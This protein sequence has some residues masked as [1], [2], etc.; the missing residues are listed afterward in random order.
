MSQPAAFR[1]LFS[2]V[3]CFTSCFA[4]L[5]LVMIGH[6]YAQQSLTSVPSGSTI[7]VTVSAQSPSG[8]P[9]SYRWLATDGVVANANTP[10]TSPN[11]TWTLPK[12]QG[13]HFL[14]VLVSDSQGGYTEKRI[15]IF[16]TDPNATS[17]AVVNGDP[18]PSIP[19][20][21]PSPVPLAT[22]R[23]WLQDQ[24]PGISMQL[25]DEFT[26]KQFGPVITDNEGQFA[27]HNLPQSTYE[28]YIADAPGQPF[29]VASELNGPFSV[30][31]NLGTSNYSDLGSTYTSDR[32]GNIVVSGHVTLADGS[33]CGDS[34][35]FFGMGVNAV[36]TLVDST[37]KAVSLPVPVNAYG[38][39]EIDASLSTTG[40]Y[41]VQVQCENAPVQFA[42]V[43]VVVD[44]ILTNLYSGVNVTIPSTPPTVT[45]FAATLNGTPIQL[46][47]A[48]PATLPSDSLPRSSQF[49]STK[50]E[51][52]RT[53]ACLYYVAV[54]A[55]TGCDATGA[56]IGGITFD[57]WKKQSGLAPYNTTPEASAT[58]TNQVD[59][60]LTRDHHGIQTPNG[61]AM[62]VCNYTGP[63]DDTVQSQVDA[64]VTNAASNQN[65][66]ACVAMDHV[67]TPGVNGGA[68][69]TR[70]LTFGP[71]GHLLL[72][73]N[74]D[75]RGEKFVPGTCVACHGGENYAGGYPT[76]GTG[77]ANIG[78]H[79]LPFDEGNF[80]FSSLA[81]FQ[82]SD[83]AAQI[84][85]LNQL[86]LQTNATPSAVALINAWYLSG[87]NTEDNS[88][89]PSTWVN[90]TD[91]NIPNMYSGVI[92]H[93]C[94]TCHIAQ[95][96]QWDLDSKGLSDQHGVCGGNEW[97]PR[98][99]NMPNSKVTFDRMWLS[100]GST[101][102]GADQIAYITAWLDDLNGVPTTCSYATPDPSTVYPAASAPRSCNY[103]F[104]PSRLSLSGAAQTATVKVTAS[105]PA[106]SGYLYGQGFTVPGTTIVDPAPVVNPAPLTIFSPGT[107]GTAVTI[108]VTAN[109]D[110]ATRFSPMSFLDSVYGQFDLGITQS[111]QLTGIAQN[112][113]FGPLNN[114]AVGTPP[115]VLAA[116]SSSGL[117][118]S[119]TSTTTGVCTLAGSTVTL[120]APG[121]C[122]ISATQAGNTSYL[123]ATPVVQ[124]FQ[125]TAGTGA[126]IATVAGNGTA[127]YSG[128]NGL[129]T[130]AELYDPFEVAIDGPGNLY[131]A[132]TFNNRVRKVSTNGVITTVA[133]NGVAGYLGDSGP[134]TSAEL[135]NP[136]GLTVDSA[137]NLYIADVHNNRVRKVSPSGTITTVAGNGVAGYGGDGGAATS[138]SLDYPA[139]VKLD[140][141]GNLY[142]ADQNNQRIRKVTTS[143]VITTVAGNGVAGYSGDNGSATSASLSQPGDIAVDTSGN[144]YIVD[145]SNNR[146]RMVNP[147]GTIT[148]VVG[149]GVGGYSG[150]NGPA[151]SAELNS[152]LSVSVDGAGNLYIADLANSRIREV[153]GGTIT[154][155]AGTG[156]S[157][158]S[159]D[160]GLAIN[161]Q[162]SS[163][164]GVSL[165]SAGNLYIAD[166]YNSRIRKVINISAAKI[167]QTI[168]FGAAPAVTVGGTG[169]LSATAS[170]GLAV[171][172]TSTTTS[173]C[174]ASGSTV[175]GVAAGSCV[176]AANQAGNTTYAA[177]PQVTQ[178]ITI[179][180]AKTAQTITF[181]AV[182]TVTV[183]ST[184][185]L[186]ATAS[187]GLAVTFT[188]TTTSICT[189]SGSTVTGV[190][191]GSCV[192]A[193]N[194][195]GNTTYAAAPQ[196]TQTITVNPAKTA[197]T[198]TFGAVPVVALG[199]TER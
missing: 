150:D 47:S 109:P 128:D 27:F 76:D 86:V 99:H 190:A 6:A 157:G 9:L 174:T 52:S 134:A 84:K 137:G 163:P 146:I 19:S 92:K 192:V 151:T 179:S 44:P 121:T 194:Q 111:A 119:L 164:F 140:S 144:L 90:P 13:L 173:I 56:P 93:S 183:G 165:D 55:A 22:V 141:A 88:Y 41:S 49:L 105:S 2:F 133:G 29:R 58:Y 166:T 5:S 122:T 83:Q 100:Q 12:G 184:G 38:N 187:S 135:N 159:G 54:G 25:V 114:A 102:P 156:V 186:S 79:F 155:V 113:S 65:L 126:T 178:T 138:A 14:Y 158:F 62:Y 67:A 43:S 45:G 20:V 118:V 103:T 60:N 185:T 108:S 34:S 17:P 95:T 36:A 10:S 30:S 46:S 170:S 4:A 70:F 37:D 167:P 96:G 64:A 3:L 57:A 136:Q 18:V 123:P 189:V 28:P 188:S 73:V 75:G 15:A 143:G 106:C 175:T 61:V 197:Q 199:G 23:G 181:G 162:I 125:V 33:T 152:P 74:L 191:A 71:S 66:V 198:I 77:T 1:K 50:G 72:S 177:A 117:P 31:D 139:G 176:V 53:G 40:T 101:T 42:P 124:S 21:P 132:D 131:I 35:A 182:P 120:V 115:V 116:A 142:I 193:A 87:S 8:V 110:G 196:V 97:L 153:S 172:F 16:T 24:R 78:A 145:Q 147:A 107:S 130:S 149:N 168:T 91:A 180:P 11:T 98:N 148:T 171:T 160:N 85:A 26:G 169:T 82:L 69:F 154:T 32:L 161:A 80:V 127:G 195:A 59:L 104:S 39:Y 68:P 89:V 129:A 48:A 51:D 81:G 94:R 63:A 112:I 7:N